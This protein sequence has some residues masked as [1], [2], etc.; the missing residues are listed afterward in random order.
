MHILKVFRSYLNFSGFPIVKIQEFYK[1]DIFY[2]TTLCLFIGGVALSLSK[3]LFRIFGRRFWTNVVKMKGKNFYSVTKVGT[4]IFKNSI[5]K[6]MI[7][8]GQKNDI[9]IKVRR[10]Y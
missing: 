3:K 6:E 9:P 2:N 1:T 7:Q 5:E 4:K 10:K 8:I